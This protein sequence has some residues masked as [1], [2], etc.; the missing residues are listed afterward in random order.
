MKTL[1]LRYIIYLLTLC[2]LCAFA[3]N[4]TAWFSSYLFY[5]VLFL[6]LFSLLLSLWPYAVLRLTFRAPLQVHRGDAAELKITAVG[7]HCPYY[8]PITMTVT[9]RDLSQS[10]S[11][12]PGSSPKKGIRCQFAPYPAVV[13]PRRGILPQL[14]ARGG[15]SVSL[16]TMHTAVIR[17]EIKSA[18]MWDFLGLFPLPMRLSSKHTQTAARYH[19]ITVL[20]NTAAPEGKLR[21]WDNSQSALIPTQRPAEQYEIRTYRP[22]D[23]LRSVHWKLTAKLDDILVRESVEPRCHVLAIALERIPD[24]EMSDILYDALDWMLRALCVKDRVQ[25]VIVGWV[26]HDGRTCTET[27]Y[28]LSNLDG[29]YRR[30]LS[31]AIPDETPPHAFAAVYK[32][33]DRGYHL[34]IETC[35]GSDTPMTVT[36]AGNERSVTELTL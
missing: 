11:G 32:S 27:L 13:F 35:L 14:Q 36:S 19:D 8:L 3:V 25:S 16:P 23:A 29:F 9:Q 20:P 5:A 15:I 17:T 30:M 26:T 1:F 33:A 12:D 4:Y 18:Y 31:D 10:D 6:P 7:S 2:G 22:G 24:R 28:D 21:M 34:D